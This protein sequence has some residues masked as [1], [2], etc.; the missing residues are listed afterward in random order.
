MS[1]QAGIE[2]SAQQEASLAFGPLGSVPKPSPWHSLV[3]CPPHA[4]ALVY[5]LL[6]SPGDSV[7]ARTPKGLVPLAKQQLDPSMHAEGPLVYGAFS[8]LPSELIV[9]RSDG[10]TLSSESLVAKAKEDAEFCEGLAEG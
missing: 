5:G 2:A 4:F 9:R 7:L 6:V 1:A 3:A 8:S 10:S